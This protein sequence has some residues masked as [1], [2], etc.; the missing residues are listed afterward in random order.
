MNFR[1]IEFS[2]KRLCAQFFSVKWH[3]L[4]KLDSVKRLFSEKKSTIWPFG[5][6]NFRSNG[7]RSNDISVEWYFGQMVFR[8]D[9]VS[10]NNF[11]WNDFSVKWSR[12]V[13][14]ELFL[15]YFPWPAVNCFCSLLIVVNSMVNGL[16]L[17]CKCKESL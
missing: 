16:L 8:S 11:R 6:M 1:S 10:I 14:G 17:N 2:V 9:G 13:C 7:V 15:K 12:T 4:S 5:K 3:F